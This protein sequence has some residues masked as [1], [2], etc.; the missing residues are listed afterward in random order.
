MSLSSKFFRCDER[1]YQGA[2]GM[3]TFF[4]S[5]PQISWDDWN[6]YGHE[7][8]LLETIALA[9]SYSRKVVSI[10]TEEIEDGIAL[11]HLSKNKCRSV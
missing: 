5:T 11:S 1:I 8:D 9:R 2:V 3:T 4:T 7:V 6:S 10:F